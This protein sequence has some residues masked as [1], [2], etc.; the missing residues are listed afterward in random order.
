MTLS[1]PRLHWSKPKE[2]R[3]SFST[4]LVSLAFAVGATLTFPACP[5]QFGARC[6]DAADCGD[7]YVCVGGAAD[8]ACVPVGAKT[9][10]GEGEG[11]GEGD[12]GGVTIIPEGPPGEGGG[13]LD[14]SIAEP[15]EC[16]S[17]NDSA[18]QS[19]TIVVLSGRTATGELVFDDDDD[20]L[21]VEGSF[22]T[23]ERVT[24]QVASDTPNTNIGVDAQQSPPP[25]SYG[26]DL[27]LQSGEFACV[28]VHVVDPALVTI[29]KPTGGPW[30]DPDTWE[31][32]E[33]PPNTGAAYLPKNAS[34]SISGTDS[35]AV[36]FVEHEATLTGALTVARALVSGGTIGIVRLASADGVVVSG[37]LD[38]VAIANTEARQ[39]G[40]VSAAEIVGRAESGSPF[41]WSVGAHRLAA[42]IID[43]SGDGGSSGLDM[44]DSS[45]VVRAKVS[46]KHNVSAGGDAGTPLWNAGC[47]IANGDFD[48]ALPPSSA[49][50][51]LELFGDG[52]SVNFTVSATD[53]PYTYL[54]TAL[55][56]GTGTATL[57]GR[58]SRLELGQPAQT[59]AP[60]PVTGDAA[61]L[62]VDSLVQVAGGDA[63]GDFITWAVAAC[64]PPQ[65]DADVCPAASPD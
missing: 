49:D 57:S 39:I 17:S 47:L 46:F 61:T 22:E 44:Q 36:L 11:E 19:S 28:H 21:L 27:Q 31:G 20:S 24:F 37:Q 29:A 55:V 60:D 23:L 13:S 50:H 58:V 2:S 65:W 12:G 4:R 48:A 53:A 54:G 33:V 3:A 26:I 9:G 7:G 63:L 25:G 35:V 30:N 56:A 1:K 32:A 42:P 62:T 38:R 18:L 45:G 5:P 14:D 59:P 10:E 52:V 41:R 64:S 43:M 6:D 51:R 34:V 16:T 8:G 15:S 40:S